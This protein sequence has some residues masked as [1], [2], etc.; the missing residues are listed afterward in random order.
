MKHSI[1]TF[2]TEYNK[3]TKCSKDVS[4]VSTTLEKCFFES[5]RGAS[6]PWAHYQG[7]A[8]DPPDPSPNNSFYIIRNLATLPICVSQM[9]MD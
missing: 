3:E 5:F 6:T 9:T 8:L 4:R 1:L 2:S 7:L